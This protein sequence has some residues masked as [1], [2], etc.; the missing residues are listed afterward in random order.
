MPLILR[1]NIIRALIV[2]AAIGWL[3]V[4]NLALRTAPGALAG[5]NDIAAAADSFTTAR[6]ETLRD[7]TWERLAGSVDGPAAEAVATQKAAGADPM[8]EAAV[9]TDS[10]H[11]TVIM[12]ADGRALVM[13]DYRAR[14]TLVEGGHPVRELMVLVFTDGNWRIRG[15][16]QVTPGSSDP[17]VPPTVE[18]ETVIPTF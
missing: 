8:P 15:V 17:L 2:L 13:S 6:F 7:G 4:A 10:L 12:A 9:E 5:V 1:S 16:W 11:S 3:L 18:L 14:R